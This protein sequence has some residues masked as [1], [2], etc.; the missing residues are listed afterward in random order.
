MNA[1]LQEW[2]VELQQVGI[3]DGFKAPQRQIRKALRR[4][5]L[6]IRAGASDDMA[7]RQQHGRVAIRV[8]LV[9]EAERVFEERKGLAVLLS[10]HPLASLL[11]LATLEESGQAQRLFQ[12]LV[13]A[14]KLEERLEAR[15][16]ERDDA[17]GKVTEQRFLGEDDVRHVSGKVST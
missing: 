6:R 14:H 13:A 3:A 9:E 4:K 8:E 7:Q 17:R 12:L 5:E 10:F 15:T 1:E 16:A 11:S 2:H